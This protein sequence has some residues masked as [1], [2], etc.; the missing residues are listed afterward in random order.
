MFF[1]KSKA[2]EEETGTLLLAVAGAHWPDAGVAVLTQPL[3]V[4]GDRRLGGGGGI[5]N[6][7]GIFSFPELYY[8]GSIGLLGVL[9]LP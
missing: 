2:E 7:E 1:V 6:D 5:G 4:C 3:T 8:I 9:H